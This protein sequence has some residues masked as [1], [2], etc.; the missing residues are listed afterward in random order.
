MSEENEKR[1]SQY[2]VRRE[3]DDSLQAAKHQSR[4]PAQIGSKAALAAP[5]AWQFAKFGATH[6]A[7][8]T[9]NLAKLIRDILNSD[10]VYEH[11]RQLL[12][13]A[14]IFGVYLAL[15]IILA[16]AGLSFVQISLF[17]LVLT[18]LCGCAVAA[19]LQEAK[20]FMKARNM[21]KVA[22][23]KYVY[24][25]S[26]THR[27]GMYKV[28]YAND[29]KSRLSSY[30]TGDPDR[31][32]KVEYKRPTKNYREV[33]SRVHATFDRQGEWVRGDLREIIAAI[34]YYCKRARPRGRQR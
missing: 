29:V 15:L 5:L 28:G 14:A 25:I 30:Q 2:P 18:F 22:G 12:A 19:K 31:S 10:F 6:T 24:V 17:L 1:K 9:W 21:R 23:A 26:N 7:R 32:F 16:A 34:D 11:K 33:E 4:L 20:D 13:A 3:Y 8:A 27:H